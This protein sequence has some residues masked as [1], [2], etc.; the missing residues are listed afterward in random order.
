MNH[1]LTVDELRKMVLK[2][3]SRLGGS[4][5][6][7]EI[8]SEISS[9]FKYGAE[10]RIITYDF[11]DSFDTQLISVLTWLMQNRLLIPTNGGVWRITE[12]GGDFIRKHSLNYYLMARHRHTKRDSESVFVA[13]NVYD[14]V[15]DSTVAAEEEDRIMAEVAIPTMDE[16]MNPTLKALQNL[17]GSGSNSEIHD[18]VARILSLSEE[19]LNFG[20]NPGA[21]YQTLILGRLASARTFLKEY[22]MIEN[23]IPGSWVLTEAGLQTDVV[24]VDEVKRV[25]Y[26]SIKRRAQDTSAK[27]SEDSEPDSPSLIEPEK[28]IIHSLDDIVESHKPWRDELFGILMEL[29]PAAFERFFAL[30]FRAEGIDQVESVN[31]VG[32]GAIEGVMSSS[33]F[34]SFRVFFKFTRGN[35]LMSTGDVD[36]F[37]R[38]VQASRS[39]KG[40]LITTGSFTQEARRESERGINPA[41][42]IIDGH[43]LV[44]KLKDLGMGVTTRQVIVEQVVID[45][46]WFLN[47]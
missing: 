39:D 46:D 10:Q 19:Q 16:L 25:R 7:C 20:Y 40:L 29:T 13:R 9:M 1:N 42:E 17:G 44:D 27:R 4:G 28:K 32:H 11:D 18:E 34:L 3:V 22:G 30:I 33:G 6:I 43:Q 47:V 8:K 15:A 5:T 12:K 23:Q 2:A 14:S 41:I 45:E 37:R 24:N 36:D 21:S 31:S 38:S 26:K 35:S